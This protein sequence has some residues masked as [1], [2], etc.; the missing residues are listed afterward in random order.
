MTSPAI[1]A[2]KIRPLVGCCRRF[3]VMP[4]RMLIPGRPLMSGM[5]TVSAMPIVFAAGVGGHSLGACPTVGAE[6]HRNRTVA[7]HGQPQ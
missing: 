2:R 1:V 4:V 6:R 5:G 7:L 3:A